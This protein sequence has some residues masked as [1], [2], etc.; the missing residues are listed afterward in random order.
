MTISFTVYNTPELKARILSYGAKARVLA[1][2]SL[3]NAIQEE[4]AKMK[5]VY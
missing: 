4:I 3:K 2:E 1:P 5:E